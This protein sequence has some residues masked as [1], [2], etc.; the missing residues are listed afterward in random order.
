MTAPKILTEDE[1]TD[2]AIWASLDLDSEGCDQVQALV[3]EVREHRARAAAPIDT[4]VRC[5]SCGK[6][7]TSMCAP[8][9]AACTC[10]GCQKARAVAPTE[11][12][13]TREGSG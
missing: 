5:E 3:A 10:E 4:G 13:Q 12:E 7:G 2:L 8:C 9:R 1:L 6:P 11:H